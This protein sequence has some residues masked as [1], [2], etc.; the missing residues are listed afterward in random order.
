MISIIIP[1]YQVSDYV[2]RCIRSVM[3]QTYTDIECIIVD[4][5]TEDDSIEKCERLINANLLET[6]VAEQATIGRA[7][8]NDNHNDSSATK[9]DACPGKNHNIKF[10]ILH[11]E[12]NRGLSAARNT[13]TKAAKG[14]YLYYLDSDDYI[15]PDCIEKLVSVVKDDPSIEMVQGNSLMKYDGKESLLGKIKQPVRISNNDEARKEFYNN[16]DIYISVW[17]RLL[18]KS[19]IEEYGLY[20]REG[21]VFEDLLWVFY[22]MKHLRKAYLYEGITHYYCLRQGSILIEAKPESVRCYVTIFNEIFNNLSEGYERDE[23]NGY[24][25]YFIKRHVSY[26]KVVAEFK[27]TICLYRTRARQ[28]HCWYVFSVLNVVAVISR[29]GNPMVVMK[30]M[31]TMRWLVKGKRMS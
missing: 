16:R 21:L 19:F 24:L 6:A 4:D 26:V 8:P 3:A 28:Y 11:H 29:F 15:A 5:A 13:G 23:I 18:K 2:E 27:G 20:C 9:G 1:V 7:N 10:K 30:T 31:N 22:L 17:N 14:E 12:V 25:Y